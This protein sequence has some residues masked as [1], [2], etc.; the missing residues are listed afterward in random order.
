MKTRT[1]EKT[2]SLDQFKWH[3]CNSETTGPPPTPTGPPPTPTG[4]PPAPTTGPPPDH[5]RIRTIKHRISHEIDRHEDEDDPT[6]LNPSSIA[7]DGQSRNSGGSRTRT[8][9]CTKEEVDAILIQCGR[10]SRSNSAGSQNPNRRR[11][12]LRSNTSYD[13]DLDTSLKNDDGDDENDEAMNNHHRHREELSFIMSES[14]GLESPKPQSSGRQSKTLQ[15]DPLKCPRCE[16][17][18]TK[19]CYYN[20]YNKMQ[21]RYVCK[22]CKRHWTEG[23]ILRSVPIGGGRKN[24]RL[25]RP[26]IAVTGTIAIRSNPS[27]DQDSLL[28]RSRDPKDTSD[29]E[30][31]T[32]IEELKGLISWDFNGGFIGCTMQQLG[33]EVED[34]PRLELPKALSCFE[35]NASSYIPK[36]CTEMLENDDDS[37]I[38]STSMIM[39]SSQHCQLPST[40]NFLELNNWNW[41]D[42]DTMIQDDMNKPWEDPTFR[43]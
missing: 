11:R 22:A 4:P 21:P 9:S 2:W 37:T 40:S 35:T 30:S 10:F 39:P 33:L 25:R 36:T 1:R 8:S 14:E 7:G 34:H 5:L 17:T 3:F 18:N 13:F 23:G 27:E 6:A 24:K 29:V 31:Y 12:Y 43:T 38:T 41:N 32:D 16:S 42:L 26:K 28:P 20:N 19:F 15:P